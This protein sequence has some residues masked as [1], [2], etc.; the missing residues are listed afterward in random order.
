MGTT[1]LWVF[2]K[3]IILTEVGRTMR[4]LYSQMAKQMLCT[5]ISLMKDGQILCTE[6]QA[7][8]VWLAVVPHLCLSL[9]AHF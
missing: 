6:N 1:K 3:T 8:S 7:Q 2:M 4:V 5:T 9:S